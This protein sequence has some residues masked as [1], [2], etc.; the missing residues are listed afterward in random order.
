MPLNACL[1]LNRG[2]EAAGED[3]RW[4]AGRGWRSGELLWLLILNRLLKSYYTYN[5]KKTN[6][7]FI[8]LFFVISSCKAWKRNCLLR[9]SPT[10]TQWTQ[11]SASTAGIWPNCR[12]TWKIRLRAFLILQQ[13]GVTMAFIQHKTSKV[14]VCLWHAVS[15]VSSDL[16]RLNQPH[17]LFCFYLFLCTGWT[18]DLYDIICSLSYYE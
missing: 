10:E 9:L 15:P 14:W 3:L 18:T 4:E 2:E 7:S 5:V 17:Y 16:V 13:K 11:S 1:C 6:S 8:G 12:G